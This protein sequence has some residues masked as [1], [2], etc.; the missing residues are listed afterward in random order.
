MSM[1]ARARFAS[2]NPSGWRK[3]NETRAHFTK[4]A[5]GADLGA[6]KRIEIW[7][8]TKGVMR[9]L[10]VSATQQ[11]LLETLI[12]ATSEA[13]WTPGNR[14]IVWH[15]NAELARAA[16]LCISTSTVRASLAAL[17]DRGLVTFR[18]SGNCRRDGH[19]QDGKIVYAYGIDLSV[20]EARYDEL[21]ALAEAHDAEHRA[22]KQAR[23]DVQKLRRSIPAHLQA[24]VLQQ[25]SGRWPTFRRRYEKIVARLG[26][27]SAAE[28]SLLHRVH[29]ALQALLDQVQKAMIQCAYAENTV[30]HASENGCLLETTNESPSVICTE[31]RH[32]AN[33]QSVNSSADAGSASERGAFEKPVAAGLNVQPD[34]AATRNY[35]IDLQSVLEACPELLT[36][37]AGEVRN[38]HD[39]AGAAAQIRPALGI[40][41]SAWS[42]ARAELGVPASAVA[43][44]IIVQKHAAGEIREP[45]AYLRGLTE[46]HRAGVLQLDKSIRALLADNNRQR[47]TAIAGA[48]RLPAKPFR[49]QDEWTPRLI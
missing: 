26:R 9:V 46:R 37:A 24:A 44:A 29:R 2:P 39:L 11:I 19:R 49:P 33:A 16:G 21:N 43:L 25:L 34:Q 18:D 38:W 42:E 30:A 40:S 4:L 45:G 36:W 3:E 41:P 22:L 48:N 1:T 5:N 20:L 28:V 14:P 47:I 13:D 15:S 35:P 27:A 8:V 6:H 23:R 32:C 10:K 7:R 17:A 31:E 12:F